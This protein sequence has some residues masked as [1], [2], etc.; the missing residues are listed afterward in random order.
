VTI[1]THR[2]CREIGYCNRGLRQMCERIGVDWSGFLKNG[3]TSEELR[4]TE[5]AMAERVIEHAEREING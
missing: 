2:H 5:N 1:I 4:K 3:I